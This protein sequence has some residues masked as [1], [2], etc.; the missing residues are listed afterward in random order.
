[1]GGNSVAVRGFPALL[2]DTDPATLVRDLADELGDVERSRQLAQA[3]ESVLARLACHSAVRVGQSLTGEQIQA[4]LQSMDSIDFANNCPHGRPVFITCRGAMWN[5]FSGREGE[6]SGW[7]RHPTSHQPPFLMKHRILLVTGPTGSGKTE[8]GIELAREFAAEIINAD[9]RQVFRGLE[10]GSAK[11]TP[12][13]RAVVP[14]HLI[15]VVDPDEPFDVARFRQL[16]LLAVREVLARDRRV[17]VVGGTGLYIKVLRGG[18]FAGPPRDPQ[19]RERLDAEESAAPGT[20]YSRLAGCDPDAAHKLHPNDRFRLIRALE[21][22]EITGRPISAWQTEHAFGDSEFQFRT[23][24]LDVPRLDLYARIDQRCREMIESGLIEEVRRLHAAGYG[25]ELPALQSPGYREVGEHLAGK[26]ELDEVIAR[27]G[28]ATRRL[29]KRQLT[30]L[31]GDRQSIW[32]PAQIEAL[33]REAAD[34]WG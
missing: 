21:V 18:L 13:Q 6:A 22:Y 9:S 8:L 34:F 14:H 30:W 23:V 2:G 7:F 25:P 3:A 27:M 12:A 11:P 16:A 15:D 24:A 26:Y 17:L 29:A 19:I 31:R 20:L 32:R 4:L 5:G 33:R 10:V 28:Q 1:M